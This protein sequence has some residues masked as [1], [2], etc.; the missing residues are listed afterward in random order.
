[1]NAAILVLSVRVNHVIQ[2]TII[3]PPYRYY[4]KINIQSI[5]LLKGKGISF[6]KP[7]IQSKVTY[8]KKN[9]SMFRMTYVHIKIA[10]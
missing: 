10:L 6:S 7:F 1:M 5:M 8:P 4:L 3:L 2:M 9:I